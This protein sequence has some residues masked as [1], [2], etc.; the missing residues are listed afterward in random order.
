[1]LLVADD[2]Y[3]VTG[4]GDGE[5]LRGP[6]AENC[7]AP[8]EVFQADGVS[9]RG[10]SP[11]R[12]EPLDHSNLRERR[13]SERANHLRFRDLIFRRLYHGACN[14]AKTSEAHKKQG[15]P[16]RYTPVQANKIQASAIIRCYHNQR[17]PP[18]ALQNKALNIIQHNLK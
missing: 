6:Q 7:R 12:L 18:H 13:K 3:S 11:L 5:I 14:S 2:L 8:L 10:K 15:R 16:T 9:P 17:S 1:M 4:F